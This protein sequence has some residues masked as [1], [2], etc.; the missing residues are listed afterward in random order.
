M[1][2]TYD[3]GWGGWLLMT[4]GM[5]AFWGFVIYGIV[6]LARG[7]RTSAPSKTEPREPAE[8]PE[9]VLKRRLAAGEITVEEYET[10][11]AVVHDA[12]SHAPPDPAVR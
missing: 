2:H 12:H 10:V 3:V 7:A 9:Q 4:L 5:G 6:W 1:W 11:R 8:S